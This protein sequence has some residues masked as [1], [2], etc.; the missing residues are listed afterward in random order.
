MLKS[1]PNDQKILAIRTTCRFNLGCYYEQHNRLGE[2]SELYKQIIHEEPNYV[3]A[4]L[5]LAYLAKAR[6][7]IKRAMEYIEEA[8]RQQVKKPEEYSKPT[9]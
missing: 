8:K 7:D 2:A 1:N 4:Y 6:G 5:R 3:D 9:N